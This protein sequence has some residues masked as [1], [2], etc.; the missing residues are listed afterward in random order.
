MNR[1]FPYADHFVGK[2]ILVTGGTGFIGSHLVRCLIGLGATVH[3]AIRPGTDCWRVKDMERQIH[4]HE[5]SLEDAV[6]VNKLVMYCNPACL[7]NFAYP[8][9]LQAEDPISLQSYISSITRITM[10]LLEAAREHA[11]PRVFH[12]CSSTIYGNSGQPVFKES[13]PLLPDSTRGFIKLHARNLCILYAKK[14]HVPVIL[15]RIFRAYGPWDSDKKLLT[16][17]L[18]AYYTKRPIQL[19]DPDIKRDYIFIDDL[20]HCILLACICDLPAGTEI[21]MGS[22]KERS[23]QEIIQVLEEILGGTIPVDT[24]TPYSLKEIDK[25][26]WAADVSKAKHLLGWHPTTSLK[27]GI[28]NVVAWYE[29]YRIK[30]PDPLS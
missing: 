21:N 4:F 20:I 15:G 24:D 27:E 28:R 13:D 3:V 10:N 22:G 18:D 26:H 7:F 25:T 2:K 1:S 9:Q 17:A 29:S 23:V 11:T 8:G 5:L 16:K 14:W 30:T 12:A 19:T 6:S